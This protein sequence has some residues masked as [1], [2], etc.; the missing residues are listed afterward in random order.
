MSDI[1]KEI[2]KTFAQLIL[3]EKAPFLVNLLFSLNIEITNGDAPLAAV[4]GISLFVNEDTFPALSNQER[5]GLLVHEASHVAWEHIYRAQEL[6]LDNKIAN[7]AMDHEI[8]LRLLADGWKLPANGLWDARFKDMPFEKIYTLLEKDPNK[9]DP[10]FNPDVLPPVDGKQDEIKQQVQD[11]IIN[12]LTACEAM[13]KDPGNLPES[14]LRTI[15]KMRVPTIPW[16]ILLMRYFNERVKEE[17][18]WSRRNRRIPDIYLPSKQN[19]VMNCIAVYEDLSG[20]ITEKQHTAQIAQMQHIKNIVNPKMMTYNG[21]TTELG[22]TQKFGQEVKDI[23]PD[24]NMTGGT[25]VNPVIA[26]ILK[27]KPEIAVIFTDGYFS[28][29]NEL[30]KVRTDIIWVVVSNPNFA[31]EKGKIIHM[32]Y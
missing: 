1:M 21:W 19:E 8:N 6:G 3:L 25:N 15:Q 14:L 18:S 28:K 7:Q 32:E 23:K 22:E 4:D 9:Q 27:N 17:V 11:K 10:N 29:P 31:A 30:S 2:D 13:G 5:Q 20:S 12:A 24:W 16:E 26:D